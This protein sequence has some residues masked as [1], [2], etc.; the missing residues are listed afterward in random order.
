MLRIAGNEQLVTQYLKSDRLKGVLEKYISNIKTFTTENA[1]WDEWLISYLDG[2]SLILWQTTRSQ[3][4]FDTNEFVSWNEPMLQKYIYNFSTPEGKA[5]FST[6]INSVDFI[7]KNIQFDFDW[8]AMIENLDNNESLRKELSSNVL[9]ELREKLPWKKLCS[10]IQ[11]NGF[12]LNNALRFKDYFDFEVLSGRNSELIENLLKI[13]ELNGQSWDWQL[14]TSIVTENFILDN[15]HEYSWD[16]SILSSKGSNFIELAIFKHSSYTL[17]WQWKEIA[18]KLSID[19]IID[20]LPILSEKYGLLQ[21]SKIKDFWNA[22]THKLDRDFLKSTAGKFLFQWDWSFITKNLFTKEEIINNLDGDA[23]YWDW[24]YL[25]DGILTTKELENETLYRNI[26]RAKTLV[27]DEHK[28]REIIHLLTKI[29]LRKPELLVYWMDIEKEDISDTINLDWDLLSNH[30]QF[31]YDDFFI[32]KYIDYWNWELL[33]ANK[34]IF[35]LKDENNNHSTELADGVKNRL[36]NKTFRWNWSVLSRNGG[37]VRNFKILSDKRFIRKWDWAY[38]SEFSE[39][40]NVNKKFNEIRY[41]YNTLQDFIDWKLL[42]RRKDIHFDKDLLAAF[43]NK[44]WD[45]QFLSESNHLEIDNDLLIQLQT[46]PW[47]WTALSKNK[48]ISLA[49]PRTVEEAQDRP[50][51]LISLK[52]KEWDW[53]YLSERKD[54]EISYQL[55]KETRDKN[56][57]YKRLTSHFLKDDLLLENYLRLLT[58]KE[59]NWSL[60]SSSPKPKFTLELIKEFSIYWDWAAL[61]NNKAIAITRELIT[62]VDNW[63]FYILTKRLEII[64][65]PDWIFEQRNKQWDWDYI[66]SSDNFLIN[67]EFI[68]MFNDKLNFVLL[69]SNPTV[70]FT[71]TVLKKY[72]RKW[73]YNLLESN[74]SIL[75]NVEIMASLNEIISEHASIKFSQKIDSQKSKWK[76]YIYHF[77]HL[78]NAATVINSK[79]ILSRNKALKTGFSNAAGSVVENRHDAHEFARFYFRPQTPTQ[80]YNENLG[81]DSSSGYLK[82]WSYYDGYRRVYNSLWKSHYPQAL[83]LGLPRCPVPVFFRFKL[84]EVLEKIESICHISNGNM[85]TGWAKFGAI[86]TMIDK[87]NFEDLFSTISNTVSGD[88]HDYIEYSQQEFLVKN[89]FDFSNFESVEIIVPDELSKTALLNLVDF[90][91]SLSDKILIDNYEFSIFHRENRKVDVTF[92]DNILNARTDYKDKHFLLIEF[93]QP[94]NAQDIDGTIIS[95]SSKI[96]KGTSHVLTTLPADVSFKVKFIDELDREWVVFQSNQKENNLKTFNENDLPNENELTEATSEIW[97]L[98]SLDS[99]LETYFKTKIRHYTL[100]EHTVLVYKQYLKYRWSVLPEKFRKLF[101]IFLLLHDIGKPIAFLKGNKNNQYTYT[102]EILKRIWERTGYS[103][104][105]LRIVLALSSGDPIGEYFQGKASAFET[106]LLMSELAIEAKID[107]QVFFNIFMVYYQCDVSS[108]TKDAHGIKYLEHLFEYQNGEKVFD[109]QEGI[110]RFSPT[111]HEKY[112]KLKQLIKNGNNV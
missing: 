40:I 93:D 70:K 26:H 54:L 85:Q 63:D 88:W 29:F 43:S 73:N 41:L 112:S 1:I 97:K 65:H 59:L 98:I 25:L 64:E 4:G 110:L 8:V 17:L 80:F 10:R 69:S 55:I 11:K 91:N 77:T 90:G 34:N 48:N 5:F 27:K 68:D 61:S 78:T 103:N 72:Y 13:P 107:N 58:G 82:Q 75:R 3:K 84:T 87:F 6:K 31:I 106:I 108:Y 81:K 19:F 15:F 99:E 36:S 22:V 30:K 33:S 102:Q 76:G 51:I 24:V 45:W 37:L 83:R 101:S 46:N 56:W 47:N 89:E 20:I 105:E 9:F 23:G 42:S 12:I 62:Q 32:A 109:E 94:T 96:I 52:D 49:L 14:V 92:K 18:A 2:Y 35:R 67:D 60:L 66:S 57:N 100:L 28:R 39:F 53:Q 111:Y 7:R 104:D 86:N 79:K 50:G 38:I 74:Y 44:N 21:P 95:V 16:F 71:P